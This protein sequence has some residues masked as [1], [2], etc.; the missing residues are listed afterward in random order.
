[1]SK[2]KKNSGFTRQNVR[3]L[4][5]LTGKSLGVVLDMPP[6]NELLVKAERREQ[7]GSLDET[8]ENKLPPR[9]IG[10]R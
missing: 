6:E 9:V 8:R 10:R 3:D 2:K 5:H 7:E 4:N 1:M